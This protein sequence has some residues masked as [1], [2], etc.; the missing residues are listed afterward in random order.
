[1]FCMCLSTGWAHSEWRA[2]CRV[3]GFFPRARWP[4]NSARQWGMPTLH[5][6]RTPD[7]GVVSFLVIDMLIPW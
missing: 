2:P 7:N 5:L 1:M 6:E 4:S 3:A